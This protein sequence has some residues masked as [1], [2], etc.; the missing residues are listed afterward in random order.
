MSLF[1]RSGI[2]KFVTFT[3]FTL[4]NNKIIVPEGI[5]AMAEWQ[6]L[7]ARVRFTATATPAN[8]QL[9]LTLSDSQ[10]RLLYQVGSRVNIPSGGNVLHTFLPG[11]RRDNGGVAPPGF[12]DFVEI[13]IPE[14]FVIPRGHTLRFLDFV[15][16]DSN[17]TLNVSGMIGV[18]R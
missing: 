3:D 7:F 1:D 8:R 10:G 18:L 15:N 6:L 12:S 14:L 9:G 16:R 11:S 5:D 17:D 13:S 4:G 2:K